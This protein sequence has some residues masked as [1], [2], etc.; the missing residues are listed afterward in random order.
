MFEPFFTTK[1]KGMGIGLPVSK[2]IIEAHQGRIWVENRPEGGA[3][4]CF[5]GPAAYGNMKP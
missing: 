4:F 3:G 1:A 5:T 2:T